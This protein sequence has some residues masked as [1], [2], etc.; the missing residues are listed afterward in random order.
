MDKID[1]KILRLLQ[2]NSKISIREI[3]KKL[4]TSPSTV[5][6]RIKKLEKENIIKGYYAKVN[7]KKLGYGVKAFIFVSYSP[8][9]LSQEN[10]AKK[11][12]ALKNVQGVYIVSGDWDIIVEVIE[13]DVE[14]LGDFVI[15]KLRNIKGVNKTL[16]CVILK[17]IKEINFVAP[18]I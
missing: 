17:R 9:T 16:T 7:E 18:Y 3:S 15:K 14:S 8:S 4:N 12:A 10:V 11:I 1:I 5:Y 6:T 13:K 2:E